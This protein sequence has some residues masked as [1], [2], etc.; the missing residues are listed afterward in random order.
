M[1]LKLYGVVCQRELKLVIENPYSVFHYLT[2]N[3]PCKP[4]LIDKNRM[5]RGDYY[6]KPTQYWFVNFEPA[7][8]TS[9]QSPSVRKIVEYSK[10]SDQAGLCSEERSL[11]SP[12]YARNFICD[13]ILGKEQKH[14][15]QGS[16]DFS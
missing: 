8:G 4:A 9:Y 2:N 5:E 13:F 6:R 10:S 15:G 14:I 11:I 16:F 7:F 1:I 3:F 12:D